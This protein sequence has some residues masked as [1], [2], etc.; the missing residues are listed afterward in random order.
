MNILQEHELSCDILVAG[1]GPAGVPCAVAA[2]RNGAKVILCQDRAVLGGNASSEVRMHI[3]G[4]DASGTRG[5]DSAL[6]TEAREGGI[7]EEVRLETAATNEQRSASMLDLILYKLCRA[8][9]NLTLMLNTRVV[10]VE[11]SDG[12]IT[13]AIA[14]R[15]L[16][17]DRFTIAADIFVDCT[18]DGQLGVAA[19]NPFRQ[20]REGQDEYGESMAQP[21]ADGKTLGSTLLFQA[22]KHDHPMP[23]TAPDWVRKFTAE[24]FKHRPMGNPNELNGGYEYGYWWVE[25]GGEIDTLKDNELIR[26]EL[27]EIM[28]GIWNYIKNESSGDGESG[29]ADNWALD[30]FGFLPGKRESRRFIGQY[31]LNENDVAEARPFD[32]SIAFGGWYIDT[33]PPAGI[34]A[35]DEKPCIQILTPYLF[36][37]PLRSCVSANVPNLMFAGRNH[38]ATHIA[39]AATRVM[40]TCAVMGEGVGV[41]A[42]YATQNGLSPDKLSENSEAMQAIQQT[43]IKD[44][45]YLIG[46]LNQDPSDLARTATITAS[47][48]QADGAATNVVS[49]QTRAV[50]GKYGASPDR[51]NP[52]THRWLSE[53]M[54]DEPEWLEL[55][56][57]EPIRPSQVQLVFDSGLHRPLALS[58]SNAYMARMVW[59]KPQPE[60]VG[61]YRIEGQCGGE[62][63]TLAEVTGNYQRLRAHDVELEPECQ[64]DAVRVVVDATNGVDEARIC[65]VRVY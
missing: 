56:W 19:G 59:G 31:V 6:Q 32:D 53:P 26:D 55:R 4:A 20:G 63:Q 47:S 10:D 9:P 44:D 48:Q 2:A 42:A 36:D 35:T 27:L 7:I 28:L 51:A 33:H 37:I 8:E 41:A 40:A 52:S 3:V 54:H 57:N 50:H 62:W 24:D 49:G 15:Q 5:R 18:G 1:G 45:A 30:W 21:E 13:H 61:D 46:V 34:D 12:K 16:T 29:D 65:E 17:E 39:F 11:M 38:S 43:L 58:H 14:E 64:L 22:R 60:T 25:W 23:F